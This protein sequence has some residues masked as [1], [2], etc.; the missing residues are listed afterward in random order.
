[1]PKQLAEGPADH[2]RTIISKRGLDG[3]HISEVYVRGA[4]TP[5]IVLGQ[6][7]GKMLAV[8]NVRRQSVPKYPGMEVHGVKAGRLDSPLSAILGIVPRL[9]HLHAGIPTV[10][11][12]SLMLVHGRR[13]GHVLYHE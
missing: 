8:L 9:Q 7:A 6:N 12:L 4:K 13:D 3:C 11:R 1:M 5:Q 10:I 2:D